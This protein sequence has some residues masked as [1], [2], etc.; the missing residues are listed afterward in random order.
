MKKLILSIALVLLLGTTTFVSANELKPKKSYEGTAQ[1]LTTFL[2]P[3][4]EVGELENDVLVRVKVMITA[5]NEIVVLQTN[6]NNLELNNY[7]KERLNYKS[8]STNELE[9]DNSYVFEINFKS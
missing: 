9:V 2:K 6:S 8:L 3:S 4:F 1:E 5:N 7:I